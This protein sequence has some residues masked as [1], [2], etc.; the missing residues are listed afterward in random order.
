MNNYYKVIDIIN[1]Q[2]RSKWKDLIS[3]LVEEKDHMALVYDEDGDPVDCFFDIESLDENYRCFFSEG[4]IIKDSNGNIFYVYAL[5]DLDCRLD[6][7]YTTTPYQHR[8]CRIFNHGNT[9][10]VLYYDKDSEEK[11]I[12]DDLYIPRDG[13][14]YERVDYKEAG[15]DFVDALQKHGLSY[16]F[17]HCNKI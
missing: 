16:R 13:S 3:P 4:D 15:E 6:Q 17:A 10:S 9:V 7:I 5:P 8:Y 11:L 1:S 14:G 2:P 12:D